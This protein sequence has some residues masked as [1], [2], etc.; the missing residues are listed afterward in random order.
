MA[1]YHSA[2]RRGGNAIEFAMCLPL[3]VLVVAAVMDF[4]WIF[5]AQ[6]TLDAAANIG[7]RDGALMD[8]GEGDLNLEEIEEVTTLRMLAVLAAFGE[9]S[10]DHCGVSASTAGDP[11]QRSL[12]CEATRRITPIT[13]VFTDERTLRSIQV[14]RLEWQREGAP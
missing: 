8:P 11:P 6:A 5:Y 9:D 3:W 7:C 10:C 2:S 4:G 1:R 13:G 14:A 12:I